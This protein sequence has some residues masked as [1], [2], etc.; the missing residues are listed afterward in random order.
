MAAIRALTRQGLD[1][2]NTPP[3]AMAGHS[4]GIMACESLRAKGAKDAELLALLQL[5]GAAGSLV[6]RRR[7]MVGRGDKSPMVSVTNV[8]PDRIAELLEEFSTDVRT[9][10]PPVLSI[11]NGRRSVV[12]TGTPEQLGR[13]ELYCSEDHR[14][15]RGRAQE[16]APR[17]R[18][19]Q[20]GVPRRAGRG[21]LPHSAAGR[22]RRGRRPL[23]RKVRH[24]RRH[25]ARD[26]RGDLRAPDRLGGRG[27]AAARAPGRSG[28]ST[29]AR[30]TPSRA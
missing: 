11:R 5:I 8:D 18:G 16:Q 22:R 24:R 4:Q 26:D 19:V 20:P 12:I 3:V 7:G 17:R 28:S 29:S 15:G 14:E 1:L 21:R 25:G 2:Y 10:L 6:S 13:F 30:A 23:G 27:R 9:V